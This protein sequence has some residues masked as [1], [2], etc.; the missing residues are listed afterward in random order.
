MWD[1]LANRK[2]NNSFDNEDEQKQLPDSMLPELEGIPKQPH[3]A[4]KS[5]RIGGEEEISSEIITYNPH[6]LQEKLKSFGD[7]DPVVKS[8]LDIRAD[9][10]M[11]ALS[12]QTKLKKLDDQILE[13]A[14]NLRIAKQQFQTNSENNATQQ[15]KNKNNPGTGQKT[16]QATVETAADPEYSIVDSQTH[17]NQLLE[18]D[19]DNNSSTGGSEE[20]SSS[21]RKTPRKVLVKQKVETESPKVARSADSLERVVTDPDSATPHGSDSARRLEPKK[22]VQLSIPQDTLSGSSQ[23]ETEDRFDDHRKIEDVTTPAVSRQGTEK[24]NDN[25]TNGTKNEQ[26][27]SNSPS[28]LFAIEET[29]FSFIDVDEKPVTLS[30][31]PEF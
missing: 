3:P 5:V 25:D 1:K 14:Q 8:L 10:I 15:A 29:S 2:D 20:S 12:M 13:V 9:M 17:Q 16:T 24:N 27:G 18:R 23:H 7:N 6:K 30:N 4:P 22:R 26:N 31:I 28:N 19:L 11:E 21:G